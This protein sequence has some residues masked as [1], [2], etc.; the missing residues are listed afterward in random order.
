VNDF[1]WDEANVEHIAENEVT[2][3]EAEAALLDSRRVPTPA[4]SVQGERRRG[5]I[6][7]TEEGRILVVIFT[8]WRR[9]RRVVTAYDAAPTEKRRY[10]RAKR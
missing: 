8:V 3:E 6:G 1:D 7:A 4:Y 5:I 2:P 9:R 10:R